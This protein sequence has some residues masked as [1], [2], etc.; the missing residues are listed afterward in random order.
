M[1]RPLLCLALLASLLLAPSAH[2]KTRI[3][4]ATDL[5]YLAPSLYEDA[6]LLR[7]SALLGDGRMPFY[8]D[9]WL[10]AL[11]AEALA[12][13][14]DALVLTG[15]LSYNGEVLSHRALSDALAAVQASG[16]PVLVIPGNH[17]INNDRAAS[18][19]PDGV[20]AVHSIPYARYD[21]YYHAFGPEQ[22]FSRDDSS[23]SYAYALDASTVLLMLDA[24]IYE[25]YAESFG[26]IEAGTQ[27]W[28]AG[29]LGD[30]QA[31]GKQVISASHQSLLPHSDSALGGDRIV[32]GGAISDLL[33][34]HGVRLHL[35]GHLHIQHIVEKDGLYDVALSALSSQPNQVALITIGDDGSIAYATRPLS[36]DLL[37]AGRLAESRAFFETIT[38]EKTLSTLRD[39]DASEPTRA[40]MAAFAATLNAHFYAGTMPDILP[41]VQDDPALALWN[42]YGKGTFWSGYLEGMLTQPQPDMNHLTLP[43]FRPATE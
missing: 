14:P 10:S 3:L 33:I 24:G 37:P 17:D 38:H 40:E 32:N 25:P 5:H 28:M 29:I 30:A 18:Y 20:R 8:S 31:Q 39:S 4:V 26:L 34:A 11:T 41:A 12:E 2:A 27:A 23:K 6:A 16:I 36:S 13:R 42:A 9:D 43:A 19:G 15:D 7:A 22:A 35:S 21:K 1:K